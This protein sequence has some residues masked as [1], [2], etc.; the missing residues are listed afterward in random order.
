[1]SPKS[2][3]AIRVRPDRDALNERVVILAPI[4]RDGPLAAA[5]L[6]DGGFACHV[7][8]DIEELCVEVERGAGAAMLTEEALSRHAVSC[9]RDVLARQPRWS[10][11]PLIVFTSHPFAD[12]N[13]QPTEVFAD[14][15]NVTLLERPVRVRTMISAARSALRARKRQYEVR[16]LVAQLHGR[17]EERDQ[18]LAMLG[19]ELRNPLAAITLAIGSLR[20][21]AHDITHE[22]LIR[23]TK[24]LKQLVD[25][26]LEIGRITSGK[27]ILH[28]GEVDLSDVVEH[29][30]ESMRARASAHRLKLTLHRGGDTWVDGDVV[31]LE[32]VVNNLL[33]NAIKYTP[34]GGTV[35]AF[36]G[37]TGSDAVIRVKD[38]GRGIAPD[39][40]GR[41]FDLFMQADVTVDR[42]EGGLG[43]GLTLVRKLAELHGGSVQAF[44][45]G[46]G[47]GCEFTVR[48]PS[49]EPTAPRAP[50]EAREIFAAA[51]SKRIVVIEDNTDIRHLLR[52][53]LKRLGHEVE[54]SGEGSE[55]L[56]T[57]L[58]SKPDVALIDI[59]LPGLDGYAIARKVR[60]SLGKEVYLIALSGYGQAEDRARAHEAGFDVHLTKPAGIMELERILARG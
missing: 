12:I 21:D 6:R 38:S 30:V 40:L 25:D 27:I 52:T 19:H 28:S 23:Q 50:R 7:C 48:I 29:C 33:S 43:I 55:G 53:E 59:G 42:S 36:V 37:R 11:F 46:R 32:Q 20:L 31:R 39:L 2:S 3:E 1:M 58:S 54:D 18:F 22:I 35:D 26:L 51:G 41:I 8:H 9:L 24:H 44:S 15:A 49:I 34:A 10:D 57:I 16:D 5:A 60:E 17:I 45:E 13:A 47:R 4:G 14:L 56:K